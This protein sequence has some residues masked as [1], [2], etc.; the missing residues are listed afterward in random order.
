MRMRVCDARARTLKLKAAPPS[1][2]RRGRHLLRHATGKEH[3]L[4]RGVPLQ[5][6]G[7]SVV[8]RTL[9]LLG[10]RRPAASV[11]QPHPQ[12]VGAWLSFVAVSLLLWDRPK[13]PAD[14]LLLNVGH[15]VMYVITSLLESRH[16]LSEKH[17]YR[18]PK[19][20]Q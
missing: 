3:P 12:Y 1:A 8:L 13:M 7:A 2:G 20:A 9:L 4:V 19:K 6:G 16:E 14:M 17:A 5:H 15:G 11:R 10:S 18:Q